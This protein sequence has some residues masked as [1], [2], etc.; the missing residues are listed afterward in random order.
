[1]MDSDC[2]GGAGGE[3]A[4]VMMIVTCG[5][6]WTPSSSFTRA[7]YGFVGREG[8]CEARSSDGERE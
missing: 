1:V 8:V 4:L 5:T 2:G 6:G 3:S 7:V